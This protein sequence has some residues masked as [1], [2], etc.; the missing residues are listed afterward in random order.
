MHNH[1]LMKIIDAVYFVIEIDSKWHTIQTF[2]THTATKT[3][4]MIGVA[5]GLQYLKG[6]LINND[7]LWNGG[8][9]HLGFHIMNKTNDMFRSLP[10]PLSDVH[11]LHISRMFVGNQNTYNL[12][13]SKFFHSRYKKL[14]L[15]EFFH[16]SSTRNN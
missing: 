9:I 13:R 11:K 15:G 14:F 8:L 16:R 2:I 4:W 5:H 3:A 10:F 12:L 7:F 1:L 6:E